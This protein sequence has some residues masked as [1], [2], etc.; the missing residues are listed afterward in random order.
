MQVDTKHEQLQYQYAILQYQYEETEQQRH[1]W[2]KK[3][4]TPCIICPLIKQHSTTYSLTK[5]IKPESD[6]TS[7]ASYQFPSI[8]EVR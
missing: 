2:L 3:R 5:R 7:Q 4:N 6:H 1:Q 8:E